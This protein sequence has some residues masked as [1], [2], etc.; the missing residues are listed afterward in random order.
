MKSFYNEYLAFGEDG[1]NFDQEISDAVTPI[2]EKYAALDF[3]LREISDMARGTISGICADMILRRA[4]KMRKA[5]R[6]EAEERLK[7][8]GYDSQADFDA[9]VKSILSE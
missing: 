9:A 5:E 7:T 4:M 1:R 6:T 2:I 8:Q 3:S